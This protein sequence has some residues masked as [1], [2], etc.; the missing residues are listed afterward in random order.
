MAKRARSRVLVDHSYELESGLYEVPNER[1]PLRF[2]PAFAERYIRRLDWDDFT[3]MKFS[4][5]A[6]LTAWEL[7][8]LHHWLDPSRMT[9][10]GVD[11]MDLSFVRELSRAWS[12]TENRLPAFVDTLVRVAGLLN[13]YPDAVE[14]KNRVGDFWEWRMT[15]WEFID[16][17]R[18]FKLPIAPRPPAAKS[19]EQTHVCIRDL[20]ALSQLV[21]YAALD[22]ARTPALGGS[23]VPG[24]RNTVPDLAEI[25][26]RHAVRLGLKSPEYS[27]A[28][29]DAA[30]KMI[31]PDGVSRA[32]RKKRPHEPRRE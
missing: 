2:K 20:P 22:A 8:A 3:V 21:V 13:M 26:K 16:F 14:I 6:D 24:D 10:G 1:I 19:C 28:M 27:N 30:V 32:G 23:Y 11:R 7:V 25:V 17:M 29:R 4:G 9:W 15:A 5:G 31:L 12:S 18:E